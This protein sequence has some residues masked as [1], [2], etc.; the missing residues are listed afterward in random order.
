MSARDVR[1]PS[2]A[3]VLRTLTDEQR[4]A[5]GGDQLRGEVAFDAE[6]H[7]HRGLLGVTKDVVVDA[8]PPLR[9]VLSVPFTLVR[10]RWVAISYRLRIGFNPVPATWPVENFSIV[11]CDGWPVYTQL[12][13]W[14]GPVVEQPLSAA[15]RW[16]IVDRSYQ[17]LAA[18]DHV[19]GI[20]VGIDVT[21][22][23]GTLAVEDVSPPL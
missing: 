13:T 5:S 14:Q 9:R 23:G 15:P 6:A 22:E 7:V 2:T 20:A 10:P 3:D 18:G 19:V 8:A 1:P 11:I 12:E 16:T 4:R 17:Q 21:V